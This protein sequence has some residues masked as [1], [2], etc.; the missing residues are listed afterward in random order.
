MS[1]NRNSEVRTSQREPGL[2]RRIFTFKAT[3]VIWL[4]LVVL[5]TT[6]ALRIVLKL[7]GA[8]PDNSVA[9]LIYGF[10]NVF[11]SPF[12]GLMPTLAS[13]GMVLEISS[14]IAMLVY[15]LVAL[16]IERLVWVIFYRPRA[17]TVAVTQSTSS[18]QQVP[19]DS[20][21]ETKPRIV[22]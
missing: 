12:A 5:E 9:A 14:F 3:Y 11:L 18:D 1:Q 17:Q 6:I 15:A 16:A 22:S 13:G 8:N 7:I 10:T 21:R 19:V 20:R 4:L 2:E